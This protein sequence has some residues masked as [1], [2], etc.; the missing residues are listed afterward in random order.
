MRTS[1]DWTR[2]DNHWVRAQVNQTRGLTRSFNHALKNVFKGAATT[3]ITKLPEHP[4]HQHYQRML[5]AGIKLN[6]AK[7]TLARQMAAIALAMWKHEEE[8]DPARHRKS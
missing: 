6:L 3:V 1:S 2:Q 8:Y 4:L 7:L 5:A